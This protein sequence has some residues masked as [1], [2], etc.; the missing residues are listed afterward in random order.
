MKDKTKDKL[1]MEAYAAFRKME[2]LKAHTYDL[3]LEI[4][5]AETAK[6][7]NETLNYFVETLE[8]E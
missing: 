7:I 8:N 6:I 5:G 2:L 3:D 1:I 4:F